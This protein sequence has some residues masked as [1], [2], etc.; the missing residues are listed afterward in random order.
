MSNPIT[1]VAGQIAAGQTTA[2]A[3]ASAALDPKKLAKLRSAAHEFESLLV[4]QLLKS[5]KMGQTGDADKSN[6]YGDMAVDAMAS[7][8]EKGG[9]LGLAKR[10]EE[11]IGASHRLA[12]T[13]AHTGPDKG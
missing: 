9:G 7:A 2:T 13:I 12:P 10:I 8:V 6:G 3:Q 4:K 11:A 1:A 5:A